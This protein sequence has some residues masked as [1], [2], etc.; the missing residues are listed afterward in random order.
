M[1]ARNARPST[2]ALPRAQREPVAIH[3]V[4]VYAWVVRI[5]DLALPGPALLVGE[6]IADDRGHFVRTYCERQLSERGYAFH[7]HQA[8]TSYNAR[9]GTLRGMHFQRAPSQEPKIVS[10]VRGAV[11]DVVVDVREESPTRYRWVS[12]DLAANVPVSLFVPS[13][14]AHGF[15]TLEDETVLTYLMG[16]PFAPDLSAGLRWDDPKLAIDWPDPV[17]P[18]VSDRDRCHPLL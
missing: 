16:A 17:S 8:N 7:L 5:V 11:H 4:G 12:V 9:R 13:G 14:F 2:K 18:I 6:P 15:Q 10:C 3:R 1:R